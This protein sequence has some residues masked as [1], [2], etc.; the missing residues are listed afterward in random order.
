MFVRPRTG[1]LVEVEAGWMHAGKIDMVMRS[2]PNDGMVRVLLQGESRVEF[3]YLHM[4]IVLSR[5]GEA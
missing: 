5:G 1:D 2:D 3:I 4:L